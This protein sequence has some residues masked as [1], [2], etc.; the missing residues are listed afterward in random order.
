MGRD[1]EAPAAPRPQALPMTTPIAELLRLHDGQPG[2]RGR[3]TA[4]GM[5][6]GAHGTGCG[7][8]GSDLGT[9]RGG[10]HERS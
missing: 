5:S 9:C 1:P 10:R 2:A 4:P 8:L 7:V 3:R 6:A